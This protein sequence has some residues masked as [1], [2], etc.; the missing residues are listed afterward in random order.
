VRFSLF[1]RAPPAP[2]R[3]NL[4]KTALQIAILWP[5]ALA[6]VPWILREVERRI[7][8]S[9]FEP[10]RVLGP[11]LL[12]LFSLGGLASAWVLVKKGE[13]TPLPMATTRR[14]VVA[15]PYRHVRN[16][17]ALTGVGQMFSVGLSLGSPS[18]LLYAVV[19]AILWNFLMRPAEESDMVRHFGADFEDYRRHVPCWIPRLTPYRP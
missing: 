2:A 7:G 18:V 17:M 1:R 10:Q 9:G 12:L 11:V 13:G 3:V 16:P 8:I 19:G 4:G 5:L 15:G 14:L 6:L